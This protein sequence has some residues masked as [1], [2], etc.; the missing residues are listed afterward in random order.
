V[1]KLAIPGHDLAGQVRAI[2]SASGRGYVLLLAHDLDRRAVLTE[3]LG[4]SMADL[5]LPPE[6]A[7]DLL[8]QTL[9]L[10]WQLPRPAG[11][12]VI[13]AEEKALELGEVVSRQWEDLGRPCP[14]RVVARALQFA[15]A[16]AAAFSADRCVVVHGDPHPANALQVVAPRAGAESGFVLIDPDGFLAD[17]A[18]DLGVVLRDWCPQLLAGDA[19]ALA[20]RYCERLAAGSGIDATAIW[21]WGFLERVST[22]LY[23]LDLGAEEMGRPFLQTAELLA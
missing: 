1:L 12:A 17:P 4:P 18:Y 22:G 5:A 14:E 9:R 23:L 8:G 2:D 15:E 11:L 6:R 10:A 20:R 16:R 19:A 13:A 3:A 21:E 7:I